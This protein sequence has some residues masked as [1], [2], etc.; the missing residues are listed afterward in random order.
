MEDLAFPQSVFRHAF[1]HSPFGIAIVSGNNEW[2]YVNRSLAESFGYALQE[3]PKDRTWWDHTVDSDRDG[4]QAAVNACKETGGSDGYTMEKRYHRKKAGEWFWAELTV[5]VVR[6][7]QGMFQYFVSYVVPIGRPA[8]SAV[9]LSFML[10]NWKYCGAGSLVALVLI[11]WAFG[12]ITTDKAKE[13]LN[14]FL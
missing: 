11:L 13:L 5:S 3:W 1:D 6:D 2:L 10:A 12:L 7:E 9:L 4:D 14:L 8:R